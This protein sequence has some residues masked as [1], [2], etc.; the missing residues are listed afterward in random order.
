MLCWHEDCLYDMYRWLA[1]CTSFTLSS[2]APVEPWSVDDG[3][4][5]YGGKG[6]ESANECVYKGWKRGEKRGM[7]RR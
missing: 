4:Q 1:N 7:A 5:F 6:L 3:A 2:P